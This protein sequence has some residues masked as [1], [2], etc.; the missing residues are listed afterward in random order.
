MI[1]AQV[2]GKYMMIRSLNPLGVGLLLTR[3]SL[4]SQ[5]VIGP[6]IVGT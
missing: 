2:L 5:A 4:G 3:T 6:L 1:I